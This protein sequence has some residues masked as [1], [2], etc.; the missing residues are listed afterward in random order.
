MPHIGYLAELSAL[1]NDSLPPEEAIRKSLPLLR[2]GIGADEI[3]LIYGWND[4]FRCIGTTENV[5]FSD[6]ALWLINKDLSARQQPCTFD[7]TDGKVGNFRGATAGEPADLVAAMVPVQTTSDM[8]I[9]CGSWNNGLDPK[10][11]SFLQIVLP[12]LA[13]LL[14]RWLE[15]IRAERQQKQLSALASIPRVMS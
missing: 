10:Q 6:V 3:G 4:G 8:L 7:L 14:E 11:L 15:G 9:A 12:A 5:K 13:L 1:V 2:E